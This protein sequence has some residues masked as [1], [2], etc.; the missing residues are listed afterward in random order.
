M[1]VKLKQ[2]IL[3]GGDI[4]IF[5]FSLYLTLAIRYGELTAGIRESHLA[6]FTILFGFALFVFYIAGFYE[7][8]GLKNNAEFGKRFSITLLVD[9]LIAIGLFYFIPIFGIA[10]KTNLFI[11]FIIMSA[12]SYVWRTWYNSLLST[13]GPGKKMLIVGHNRVVEEVVEHIAQNPQLGYELTFTMKEGLRDKD[14]R[15]LSSIIQSH[16]INLIV[17]PAHL[18]KSSPV[19]RTIY[20]NLIFGIEVVD[21]AE[22]YETLFGKVPLSELE[23]VWFLENLAK[24]HPIHD[25]IKRPLELI[26]A[27]LLGALTLPL[28]VIIVLSIKLTSPGSAFFTQVRVGKN[29]KHFI[30]WKFRTMVENAEANGPKWSKPKDK[31][32]TPI[33]KILRRTHLDE[34]PQLWN[35]FRG[36][37]SLVGPRPERPE[38]T[39]SLEKEIPYYALRHL[40]SPG[41]TGWAQ[42]NYRYGS[43]LDDA[44][45]K[46]QYDIYYLKHRNFL[47]D[48]GILAKT[49][50]HLFV[51]AA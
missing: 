40:V 11:F 48:L 46:L 16:H 22:L 43:S 32:V 35:I 49:L 50:K 38:F 39:E 19:A 26:L 2:L 15:H 23:E 9:F 4:A 37:L 20:H 51:T 12:A 25:A 34:L 44:Y 3:I 21:L 5:Y 28:A 1:S 13:G 29:D 47:L 30:L 45:E 42:V 33:G 14:F 41:L 6:P 31:R 24:S 27:A 7:V 17:V 36:N 18:K 10:P 8:R